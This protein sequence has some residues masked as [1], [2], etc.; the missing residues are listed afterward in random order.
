MNA[1]K[2]SDGKRKGVFPYLIEKINYVRDKI[3]LPCEFCILFTR[4]ENIY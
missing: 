4:L 1:L 2:N 3:L